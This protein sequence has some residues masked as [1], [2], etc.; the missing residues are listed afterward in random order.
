[1]TLRG[2]SHT[3]CFQ[4]RTTKEV[5]WLIFFNFY[6]GKTDA[7]GSRIFMD[8]SEEEQRLISDGLQPPTSAHSSHALA[9]DIDAN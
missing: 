2:K 9:V 4:L 8:N 6:E 3:A 1:V 7:H 5:S